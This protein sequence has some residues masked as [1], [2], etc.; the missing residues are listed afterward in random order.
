MKRPS[1]ADSVK[2]HTEAKGNGAG[3]TAKV[4]FE[5]DEATY[6][7]LRMLALQTRKSNRTVLSEAVNDY[8]AKHAERMPA[9]R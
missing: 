8:L 3:G 7:R 5:L 1:L 9:K 6:T 2:K 4:T